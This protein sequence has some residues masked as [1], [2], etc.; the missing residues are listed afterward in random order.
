[1]NQSETDEILYYINRKY[2]EHIPGPVR[3]FVGRKAQNIVTFQIE[4][5]P[6]SLRKCTVE[7]LISIV[8]N[9]LRQGILKL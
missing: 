9:A 6:N 4:E 1:M 2:Y 7:N 8:Q 5:L 3:F